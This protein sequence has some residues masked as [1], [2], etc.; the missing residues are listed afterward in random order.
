M[1]NQFNAPS[2]ATWDFKHD[3]AR[4][5]VVQLHCQGGDH[6]VQN[7]IGIFQGSSILTFPAGPCY[8]EVQA[9]GNWSLTPR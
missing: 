4:N 8:W 5:F 9:D 7:R 2:G 3:G 6:L 1:S